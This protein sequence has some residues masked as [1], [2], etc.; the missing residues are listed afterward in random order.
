[1]HEQQDGEYKDLERLLR[2]ELRL[3][4]APDGFGIRLSTRLE[5]AAPFRARVAKTINWRPRRLSFAISAVLLSVVSGSY[6]IREYE[7][8][9]A[10]EQARSQ[11]LLALRI[12]ANTFNHV[13]QKVAKEELR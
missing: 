7:K 1:M 11:V 9:R 3:R 5:N 10:G 2:Q 13:Q 6:W 8:R 12:T 4:D